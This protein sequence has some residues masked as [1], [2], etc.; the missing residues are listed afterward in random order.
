MVLTMN[1]DRS[2]SAEILYS[3]TS[4]MPSESYSTDP[5]KNGLQ[6][7]KDKNNLLTEYQ[8]L[9]EDEIR[10]LVEENK[11][12]KAKTVRFL[13]D[14][15][16]SASI[17]IKFQEQ[18]RAAAFPLSSNVDF[19]MANTLSGSLPPLSNE[20]PTPQKIS[21]AAW[22]PHP[23]KGLEERRPMQPLLSRVDKGPFLSVQ[24]TQEY[25]PKE[26]HILATDGQPTLTRSSTS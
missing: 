4:T 6:S 20:N 10:N 18:Q 15:G 1:H 22:T 26:G 2:P 11:N 9:R 5:M 25:E 3:P 16:C 21:R 19:I 14:A 17:L 24:E 7:N 12:L 8:Q 23:S 13:E